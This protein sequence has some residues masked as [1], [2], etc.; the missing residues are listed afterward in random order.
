MS[1]SPLEVELLQGEDHGLFPGVQLSPEHCTQSVLSEN[2]WNGEGTGSS[3]HGHLSLL[4]VVGAPR[5]CTLP[6]GDLLG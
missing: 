1:S 2:L 3:A 4:A 5:G 6:C